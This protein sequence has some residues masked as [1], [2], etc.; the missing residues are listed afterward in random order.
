MGEQLLL[1]VRLM[2][3]NNEN[4]IRQAVKSILMQVTNFHF[5]VVIGDDFS[6]DDT[7]KILKEYSSTDKITIR[8]LKRE[9]GGEYWK[10]RNHKDAS[11]RTNFIDIVSHCK[12]KYIALLDGDDYWTDP[13]K[14]QK[15]VDFLEANK[16]YSLCYH[17]VNLEING[18]VDTD[19]NDITEKRYKNIPDK[20]KIGIDDL[21]K[22]GNFIHTPSVMFKKTDLKEIPFETK[23]ST[24]GDY[25]LYIMLT[26]DNNKFIKK[27]QDKMAVYR[28]GV[29]VY[30][31]LKSIDMSYSMLQYKIC[32]LSYLKEDEQKKI[33]LKQTIKHFNGIKK[34]ELNKKRISDFTFKELLTQLLKK[35]KSRVL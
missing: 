21:L 10:K 23:Y 34:R 22:Q 35:I 11:V 6:T 14:L 24:V 2:V 33:L 12:G 5:E 19:E 32:I 4:Y 18:I 25:F 31:S 1:S 16:E 28:R 17:R 27:L 7:L 3:Y 26:A 30:S 8:I 13:L 29:G 20:T 15:Q 9:I